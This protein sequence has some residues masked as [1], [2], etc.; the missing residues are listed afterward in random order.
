MPKTVSLLVVL[1]CAAALSGCSSVYDVTDSYGNSYGNFWNS[2]Q[3]YQWQLAACEKETAD[4]DISP[5]T[6]P[7]HM[8]CC[9][10]H[11]GV[12]ID[13]PQTCTA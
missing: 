10:Y 3:N 1:I 9:M 8:R 11:H 4:R 7:Y 2:G 5:P 6:R 13:N 12:P